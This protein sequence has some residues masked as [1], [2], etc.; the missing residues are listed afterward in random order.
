MSATAKIEGTNE[1]GSSSE[2]TLTITVGDLQFKARFED[3]DAPNTV[4]AIRRLL[5]LRGKLTQALWC[6]EAGSI[7]MGESGF[8]LGET[9][10]ESFENHTHHPAPGQLIIYPGGFSE[11]EII[12]AYGPAI[13]ARRIGNLAGNHFA[14]VVDSGEQLRE[15]GHKLIWDGA[16]DVTIEEA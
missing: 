3:A 9:E 14:T 13:F 6:G 11:L 5:P 10:H 4:A 15:L 16:Q 1:T 2:A 7:D 12:F 8:D